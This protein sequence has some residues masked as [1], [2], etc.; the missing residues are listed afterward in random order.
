MVTP[1]AYLMRYRTLRALE[2]VLD[3]EL[4]EG[5]HRQLE[6]WVRDRMPM[7][8]PCAPALGWHG[9]AC[10]CVP[11]SVF[12]DARGVGHPGSSVLSLPAVSAEI[13]RDGAP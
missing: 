1:H 9:A 7:P 4:R 3:D 10:S 8:Q 5:Y 12:P 11:L 6:A 2:Q 13:R